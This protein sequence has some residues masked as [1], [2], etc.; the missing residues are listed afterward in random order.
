MLCSGERKTA[1]KVVVFLSQYF[2]RGNNKQQLNA[3]HG[4]GQY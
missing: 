2:L 4:W 1:E 3:R